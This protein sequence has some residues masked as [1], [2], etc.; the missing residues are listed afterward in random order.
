MTMSKAS[1]PAGRWIPWS[2]FGFFGVIFLVNGIML[3]IALSSWNGIAVHDA[4]KKG[5][6]YNDRLAEAEAQAKLG[7]RITLRMPEQAAIAGELAV[8]LR[9]RD[10]RPIDGADMRARI[11]RPI[12]EGFDRDLV[13]AG[14]G[15]GRYS[16][17][18]EVPLP[19]LWEVRVQASHRRGVY[20]HSARFEV[21]P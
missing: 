9:D 2:F 7:W 21:A 20:R 8:D 19:G 5:L 1:K 13:L 14:G 10:G 4:F 17:D 16:G 6:A 12:H 15:K 18:L 11:V 3:Y